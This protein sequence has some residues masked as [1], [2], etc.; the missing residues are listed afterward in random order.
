[1]FTRFNKLEGFNE[2]NRLVDK[3]SGVFRSYQGG[4]ADD[5][6]HAFV[7]ENPELTTKVLS[8]YETSL[9][10][11]KGFTLAMPDFIAARDSM[12]K[13]NG[14]QYVLKGDYK[15]SEFN[16]LTT[17]YNFEDKSRYIGNTTS[18]YTENGLRKETDSYYQAT[19]YPKWFEHPTMGL[20]FDAS[21]SNSGSKEGW[22]YSA[23]YGWMYFDPDEWKGSQTGNAWTWHTNTDQWMYPIVGKDASGQYQMYFATDNA[24]KDGKKQFIYVDTS[25]SASENIYYVHDGSEWHKVNESNTPRD[26][27]RER[28]D[29]VSDTS[30]YLDSG[31]ELTSELTSFVKD[32]SYFDNIIDNVVKKQKSESIAIGKEMDQDPNLARPMDEGD[33]VN[34]NL[35]LY[36]N[37]SGVDEAG[38]DIA[39][40]ISYDGANAYGVDAELLISYQDRLNKIA[41]DLRSRGANDGMIESLIKGTDA[42]QDL[43]GFFGA[44]DKAE[45]GQL[46]DKM[47]RAAAEQTAQ[48]GNV[49]GNLD[50]FDARGGAM[51]D[52]KMSLDQKLA[53]RTAKPTRYA[54]LSD[55]ADGLAEN[56]GQII[57]NPDFD[58][59]MSYYFEYRNPETGVLETRAFRPDMPGKQP[60]ME[61][62]ERLI[63]FSKSAIVSQLDKLVNKGDDGKSDFERKLDVTMKKL[64]EW[65]KGIL[66]RKIKL[67][68]FL[69]VTF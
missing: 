42:Y 26:L 7:S 27:V 4:I 5:A 62:Q 69:D 36:L 48:D 23:E 51:L 53:I 49:A 21:K 1:M 68:Y 38:N 22:A 60:F 55:V 12:L 9:Q 32:D 56:Q 46:V 47:V 8:Q 65:N 28:V 41:R 13:D 11:G 34:D 25:G 44:D 67:S 10:E 61:Q 30:G 15:M 3:F 19:K 2:W 35:N 17:P 52:P 29:L 66:T 45:A 14:E 40:L 31:K 43:M 58:E 63:D 59:N 39:K 20:M 37:S 64:K 50:M 54:T 24:A 57:R 33:Y 18:E 16:K 6:A